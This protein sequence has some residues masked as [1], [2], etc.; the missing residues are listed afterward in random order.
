VTEL[1]WKNWLRPRRV[2]FA[3]RALLYDRLRVAISIGAIGFAILLVLLLRGV[4]DGTVEK[5][6]TYI[7]NVGADVVVAR[8]GVANM[9]LSA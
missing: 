9:A 8:E 1:A 4:M 2:P 5:S 7:D 3:T 6:T